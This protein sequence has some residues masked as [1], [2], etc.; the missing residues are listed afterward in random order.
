MRKF[1]SRTFGRLFI[2]TPEVTKPGKDASRS[3]I[4]P[5]FVEA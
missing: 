1:Y 2:V 5:A 4:P 3:G